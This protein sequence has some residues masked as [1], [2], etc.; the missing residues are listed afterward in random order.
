MP[1][2][3]LQR[4]YLVLYV[5]LLM[6]VGFS[7]ALRA[8]T[9][10]D[11]AM[12][13][14]AGRM[15]EAIVRSQKVQIAV[16]DFTNQDGSANAFGYRIAEDLRYYLIQS[17]SLGYNLVERRFLDKVIE[18][19]QFSAQATFDEER[20]IAL[21]KLMSA[22]AILFGTI[23]PEGRRATITT[24]LIDTE[25]GALIAMDRV[26]VR[27]SSAAVRESKQSN[28]SHYKRR[29]ATPERDRGQQEAFIP[30][31]LMLTTGVHAFHSQYL[32]SI[33]G[34]VVLRHLHPQKANEVAGTAW[35]MGVYIAPGALNGIDNPNIGLGYRQPIGNTFNSQLYLVGSG[36]GVAAGDVWLLDGYEETFD[37]TFTSNIVPARLAHVQ[38]SN[39]RM[40]HFSADLWYKFY[41]TPNHSYSNV[42]KPYLGFGVALTGLF[43]R[44]DYTG[45]ELF[46]QRDPTIS[47]PFDSADLIY[48]YT[49]IDDNRFPFEGFRNNL[50]YFDWTMYIGVERGRFGAQ[51]MGGISSR[52]GGSPMILPYLAGSG[53]NSREIERKIQE[54]GLVVFGR[55]VEDDSSTSGSTT[56]ELQPFDARFTAA[57]RLTFRFN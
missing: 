52:L 13:D 22:D 12:N 48:E 46:V 41:L 4:K 6:F 21:G 40:N 9:Q 8:Q 53:V 1:M 51:L 54:D 50:F 7:G 32:P 56:E 11:N 42:T 49:P 27:L 24:K 44:A 28:G 15:D 18:E 16:L 10:Y 38:L 30:L 29:E 19:Q 39:I 55:V 20:A 25:T 36:N 45:M 47:G 37:Y 17:K 2:I 23:R 5:C 34:Q 57:L 31:E 26:E 33:G 35:V 14:L 43:Y 3:A